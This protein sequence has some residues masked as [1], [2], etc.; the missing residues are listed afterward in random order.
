[1]KALRREKPEALEDYSLRPVPLEKRRPW[2]DLS[3]VWIG[4]AITA[5]V[6][7]PEPATGASHPADIEMA[8]R[9]CVEVAK[10]YCR[11]RCVFYDEP[12]FKRLLDQYGPLERFKTLGNRLCSNASSR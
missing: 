9:F 11:G 1:M 2:L 5:E 6:A 3:M 10:A 7:V 12:E 4:V 8:A